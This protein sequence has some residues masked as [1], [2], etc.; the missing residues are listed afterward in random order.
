MRGSNGAMVDCDSGL[1]QS[2]E[3]SVSGLKTEIHI[4]YL[5]DGSEIVVY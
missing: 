4:D 1:Q 5:A 3:N 2:Y